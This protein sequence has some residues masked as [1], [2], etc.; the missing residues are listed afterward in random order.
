MPGSSHLI[1]TWASNVHINKRK[2]RSTL[3]PTHTIEERTAELRE[4]IA[5]SR[6]VAHEQAARSR[7]LI[8]NSREI[9][10]KT[11]QILAATR[12]IRLTR[13]LAKDRP[14]VMAKTRSG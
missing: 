10:A 5:Y 2:E 11:R 8:S 14:Y 12:R 4:S 3:W 1:K 9:I 13:P 7:Q 6:A